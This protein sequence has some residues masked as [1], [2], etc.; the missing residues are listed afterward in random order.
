MKSLQL[1]KDGAPGNLLLIS[2][3]A[4]HKNDSHG[5]NPSLNQHLQVLISEEEN[6]KYLLLCARTQIVWHQTLKAT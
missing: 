3:C 6:V 5:I 1:I 4:I 2:Y